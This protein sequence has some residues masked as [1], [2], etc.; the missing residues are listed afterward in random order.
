MRRV[1]KRVRGRSGTMG[2]P[3][4]EHELLEY[5][6]NGKWGNEQW[7]N[8]HGCCACTHT[9]HSTCVHTQPRPL[10]PFQL[11]Q[12][13][14]GP[15][16]WGSFSHWFLSSNPFFSSFLSFFLAF[17]MQDEP[18]PSVLQ[19]LSLQAEGNALHSPK[20]A[21]CTPPPSRNTPPPHSCQQVNPNPGYSL[22][23]GLLLRFL[24]PVASFLHFFL[25]TS[26]H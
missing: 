20:A 3:R 21:F 25:L 18:A 4:G 1:Q 10:C 12:H 24:M 9:L 8:L 26:Q 6:C 17:P 7:S 11:Q 19:P 22:S 23:V 14:P 13:H 5:G 16:L 2:P 15:F